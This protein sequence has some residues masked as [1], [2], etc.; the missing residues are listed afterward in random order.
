MHWIARSGDGHPG[1]VWFLAVVVAWNFAVAQPLLDLLG[2]NGAFF[3]AHSSQPL[4]VVVLAVGIAVAAPVALAGG[5]ALASRLSRPVGWVLHAL[6]VGTLLALVAVQ[7]L[8]KVGISSAA[9]WAPVGVAAGAAGVVGLVRSEAVRSLV[10]WLSPAPAVFL[11][12]FLFVSPV[13]GIVFRSGAAGAAPGGRIG[14]PVPVVLVVLD[15]LPVVSLM[16]PGGG[17]DSV[18]FPN[19]ARLASMS[20]WYRN[21]TTVSGLTTWAVPAVL[22]GREFDGSRL[23]TIDDHP[24]NLFTLLDDAYRVEAYEAM[25]SLCPA[26]TCGSSASGL[27]FS[28][29]MRSLLDDTRIVAGHVVLPG[30]LSRGLPAIDHAW[31]DFGDENQPVAEENPVKHQLEV[32]KI[33]TSKGA[34]ARKEL[35]TDD[36]PGAFAAFDRGIAAHARSD[37]PGAPVLHFLHTL[38]PHRPWNHLPDGRTFSLTYGDWKSWGQELGDQMRGHHE[39]QLRYTDRLLGA[40][41]DTLESSGVLDRAL[42][43][44]T[45]DHGVSFEAGREFRDLRPS[46]RGDIAW[47]PLF[48]KLPGRTTGRIDDRPA[49]T[50]DILPTIS[51]VLDVQ[52][53]YDTPGRSLL[54]PVR[55]SRDRTI[56]GRYP[57]GPG[58]GP[59]D[60]ALAEK[61]RVL[62]RDPS[63]P[64]RLF[65][66]GRF[67][68]LVGQPVPPGIPAGGGRGVVREADRFADVDPDAAT[69]PVVV[70]MKLGDRGDRLPTGRHLLVAVDG[71]FAGTAGAYRVADGSTRYTAFLNPATLRRGRNTVALY[72]AHGDPAAPTL[73]RVPAA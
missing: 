25:T 23:P 57:L 12:L 61:V 14:N 19:F 16:D 43:I 52:D 10:R 71:V 39:A 28:A 44:V 5:L 46:T 60:R 22:D 3:V 31:G 34:A 66:I 48:V 49:T 24:R 11:A 37:G 8:G 45:A 40:T 36:P 59:R 63:D 30:Q 69:L 56:Q 9:V 7:L 72:V 58:T 51:D 17:I 33:A 65:G 4:D 50:L 32:A 55:T 35:A 15:E 62:G 42:L 38:M 68:N 21:T 26:R 13:Q 20:T 53:P 18:A 54:G 1:P 27:S 29:R 64:Q 73:E 67:G 2:R 70:T 47:V 6:V 41:L